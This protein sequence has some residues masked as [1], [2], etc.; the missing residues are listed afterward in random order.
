MYFKTKGILLKRIK[1]SENAMIIKVYT[2]K[3]GLRTFMIKGIGKNKSKNKNARLL[4]HLTLLEFVAYERK[5]REIQTISELEFVHHYK[6]IPYNIIK[7]CVI[8][9]LNEVIYKVI[10]EE[11]KN[12]LL[13]DYIFS[14]LLAYDRLEKNYLNFH[15]HFLIHLTKYLGYFP[16][17]ELVN[18]KSIGPLFNDSE[19]GDKFTLL[20]QNPDYFQLKD[21]QLNNNNRNEILSALLSFY[22]EIIENFQ[23]I[24]SLP[25]LKSILT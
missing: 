6:T 25:V 4:S 17:Y 22:T 9:F 13:F 19:L 11:E 20:L 10:K 1:Y 16:K 23:E 14:T 15:I 7:S 3:S 8:I 12:E 2:Q 21:L 5:T 18:N 24:K